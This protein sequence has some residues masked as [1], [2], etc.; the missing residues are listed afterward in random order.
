MV[1]LWAKITSPVTISSPAGTCSA[2][3]S[4]E[5]PG[6]GTAVRAS[7]R[8]ATFSGPAARVPSVARSTGTPQRRASPSA[9]PAWSAW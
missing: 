9:Q 2:T 7:A 5:C 3:E 4:L 1:G 6:R 8:P